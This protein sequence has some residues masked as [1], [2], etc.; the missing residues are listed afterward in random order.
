MVGLIGSIHRDLSPFNYEV[1]DELYKKMVHKVMRIFELN[2]VE[3]LSVEGRLEA[4]DAV[5]QSGDPRLEFNNWITIEEGTFFLG[6]Q[7]RDPEGPN[8]DPAAILNTEGPPQKITLKSFELSK[9]PVTVYDYAKFLKD[10]GYYENEFWK[11][12]GYGLWKRPDEWDAQIQYPNRPVVGISWFE[13]MAYCKWKG[14]GVCLPTEA[15]WERAARGLEGR[16]FPWGSESPQSSLLNFLNSDLKQVTP[17]GFYPKGA[18]PEGIYDLS[19]NTFEWCLDSYGDFPGEFK[20]QTGERL[21]AKNNSKNGTV[22]GGSFNNV[23]FLVRT[24]FRGLYDRKHRSNLV[25]FRICKNSP[26]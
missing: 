24:A 22:R 21:S 20:K 15:Q 16:R 25:G 5:G 7:S 26:D 23:A 8:Y 17:V 9:Y 2:G 18:T 13:A 10:H 4:A 11:E 12:G 1:K 3:S 6:A 14:F 19:G